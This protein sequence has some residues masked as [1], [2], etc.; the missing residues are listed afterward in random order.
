MAHLNH[1]Q[2]QV[3]IEALERF[4]EANP[5]SKISR[6]LIKL[7]V[8]ESTKKSAHTENARES[9]IE[10]FMEDNENEEPSEEFVEEALSFYLRHEDDSELL[11]ESLDVAKTHRK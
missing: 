2:Q 11:S 5:E 4:I 7:D 1:E 10:K 9:I 6:K 3:V 8:I